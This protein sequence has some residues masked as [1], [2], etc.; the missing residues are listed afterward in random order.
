MIHGHDP[1]FHGRKTQGDGPVALP[2]NLARPLEVVIPPHLHSHE[3][4]S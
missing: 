4:L 3:W 1:G 2:F